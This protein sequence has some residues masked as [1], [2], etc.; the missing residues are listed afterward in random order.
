MECGLYVVTA[1]YFDI[2]AERRRLGS[3]VSRMRWWESGWEVGSDMVPEWNPGVPVMVL[4]LIIII[5][6]LVFV[7]YNLWELCFG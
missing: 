4:V 1:W 6:S 5:G 3:G 2:W 7:G